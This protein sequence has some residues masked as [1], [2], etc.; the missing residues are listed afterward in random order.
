MSKF[1]GCRTQKIKSNIF[2]RPKIFSVSDLSIS[3]LS[4][5]WHDFL[6]SFLTQGK[7]N[8][9]NSI[10]RRAGKVVNNITMYE[11]HTMNPRFHIHVITQQMRERLGWFDL[12]FRVIPM[13]LMNRPVAPPSRTCFC[14]KFRRKFFRDLRV[15]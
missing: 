1:S 5:I 13:I 14:D 10:Y 2:F 4:Q 15:C 12:L 8:H 3:R 9:Q 11:I 7:N 6:K